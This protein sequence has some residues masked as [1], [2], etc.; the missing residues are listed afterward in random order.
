MFGICMF[1]K[2]YFCTIKKPKGRFVEPAQREWHFGNKGETEGVSTD[3]LR[4]V[5]KGPR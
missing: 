2:Q 4:A 3:L 5:Y 1:N